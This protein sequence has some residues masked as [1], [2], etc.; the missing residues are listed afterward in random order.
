MYICFIDRT[1]SNNSLN[2]V[3]EGSAILLSDSEG[4]KDFKDRRKSL[5]KKLKKKTISLD[6]ANEKVHEW[7]L[8]LICVQN[9]LRAW[10]IMAM[11][12]SQW[13]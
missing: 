8:K 6:V 1:A 9:F 2:N 13:K 3:D 12:I 4:S 5:P 11:M 7:V 10:V